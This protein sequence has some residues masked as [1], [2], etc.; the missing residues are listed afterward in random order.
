MTGPVVIVGGGLGA[1]RLAENLRGNGF[2]APITILSAEEHPPY[3]RPPLS[4]SVLT[5]GEDRSDLKPAGFY[6]DSGIDLR[7]G[8][9]VV[10]VDP[11]RRRVVAEHDGTRS[12]IEYGTL[13]LATGLAPRAFP[14]EGGDLTGVHVIRTYDDAVAL[15]EDLAAARRAVV[16][17]AGFIGCE[18]AASLAARGLDVTVVEPAPTPLAAALGPVVGQFVAR[19]HKEAGVDLRTGV[20]VS[21]LRPTSRRAAAPTAGRGRSETPSR[22]RVTAVE[23]DDGTVLDAD[24]VVVGIGGY[25]DL[26]YLSGSGIELAARASGGGI[27]CDQLGRTSAPDVYAIGDAANWA[28]AQG[29]RR[30]VEHW[31]HTVEQAVI[32]AAEIGG[33]PLPPPTVPYFWSDQ[34]DLKVQLLGSPRPDDDVHVVDDDGRKFLAYYSRDGILTGVVGAGRVGKLMKTRPHLLTDTPVASLLA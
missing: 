5:A 8:A 30:R 9:R 1:S 14:G 32:V 33:H 10:A 22:D 17:G 3:D 26:D 20:G 11:G 28:D 4:K 29:N 31:N 24:L 34:Y 19:L 16:I 18:A 21:R 27:A 23:L 6:A 25:P 2:D 12:E 7:L 13:V 15:R